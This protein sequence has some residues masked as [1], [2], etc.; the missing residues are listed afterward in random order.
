[1]VRMNHCTLVGTLVG[2]VNDVYL[3]GVFLTGTQKQLKTETL[4][5]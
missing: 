3:Y 4:I 2:E 1:M 5:K